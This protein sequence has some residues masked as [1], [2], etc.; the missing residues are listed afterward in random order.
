MKWVEVGEIYFRVMCT[1][2]IF[3]HMSFILFVEFDI[4]KRPFPS[5][6]FDGLCVFEV[7]FMFVVICVAAI[8]GRFPLIHMHIFK[9]ISRP[10]ISE[11]MIPMYIK[12]A[13]E[14]G[15]VVYLL[16]PGIIFILHHEVNVIIP[17]NDIMSN[18]GT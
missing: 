18:I 4:N 12:F 17:S 11:V 7:H 15:V 14:A 3:P 13:A 16:Q 8:V 1:H 6:M 9:S 5:V 10:F 2:I